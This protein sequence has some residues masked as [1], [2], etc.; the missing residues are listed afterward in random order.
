MQSCNTESS[1]GRRFVTIFSIVQP[2]P[3]P[4]DL[5]LMIVLSGVHMYRSK[6]LAAMG[7][8]LQINA[9][10]FTQRKILHAA[11]SS[12]YK[13]QKKHSPHAKHQG[14]FLLVRI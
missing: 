5:S 13:T 11:E 12:V 9:L 1:A 2:F 14:F 6:A 8:Q 10:W 7:R 4:P 3:W